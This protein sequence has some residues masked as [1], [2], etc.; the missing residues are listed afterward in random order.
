M[1][2]VRWCT[3]GRAAS[4]ASV[5]S[6]VLVEHNV[7][8][9]SFALSD[10]LVSIMTF[11]TPLKYVVSAVSFYALSYAFRCCIYFKARQLAFWRLLIATKA[12][13]P[14]ACLIAGTTNPAEA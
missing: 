8:L 9:G 5:S 12:A 10:I 4:T 13:S 3:E 6:S 2:G 11:G 7:G 1:R 14:S